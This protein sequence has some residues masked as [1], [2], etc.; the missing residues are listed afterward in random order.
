M[1]TRILNANKKDFNVILDLN[2]AALPAVSD[3][4]MIKIN[5]FFH[6]SKYFKIIKTAE[7]DNIIGFLIGL[8][9]GLNYDSEN[10]QWFIKKFD[11]FMYV[12]RI[13]IS[14][15]Y[16]G[17]GFGTLFYKDLI[18]YSLNNYK[19]IICEYNIKPMNLIS[20]NFHKKFGFKSIGT[21][22]TEGGKKEV[23][24]MEYKIHTD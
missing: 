17:K 18:S 13:V 15:E 24:L 10:Y 6:K 9:G 2:Q 8:T 19:R 5:Y 4:N 1:K 11:S 12:D 14:P 22:K 20:K 16:T 21:Q 3:M 23:S 7:D